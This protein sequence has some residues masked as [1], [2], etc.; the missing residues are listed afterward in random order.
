MGT[1][2][3]CDLDRPMCDCGVDKGHH[4]NSVCPCCCM[5]ANFHPEIFS[6]QDATLLY[7]TLQ[8]SQDYSPF[9]MFSVAGSRFHNQ[10]QQD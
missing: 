9:R 7:R 3:G 1:S 10:V 8:S 6:T 2:L 5:S 4:T